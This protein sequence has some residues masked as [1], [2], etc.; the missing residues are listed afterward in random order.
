[1]IKTSP[2]NGRE[3]EMH[4]AIYYNKKRKH[5]T[6]S[7][8]Q[9]WK[10]SMLLWLHSHDSMEQFCITNAIYGLPTAVF[11]TGTLLTPPTVTR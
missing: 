10:H 9:L 11:G 1:M 4:T 5:E 6:L 3:Y 2:L 7:D 8:H